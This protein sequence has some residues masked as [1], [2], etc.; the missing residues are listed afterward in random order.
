MMTLKTENTNDQK[1]KNG[2]FIDL[3][4]KWNFEI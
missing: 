3:M 2:N 4:R 1:L